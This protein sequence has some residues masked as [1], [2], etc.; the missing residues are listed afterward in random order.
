[1]LGRYAESKREAN[2]TSAVRDFLITCGLVNAAHIGEEES[3]SAEGRER[4]DLIVPHKHVFVEVK[5]RIGT[6]G[7][8]TTPDRSGLDQIDQ[9]VRESGEPSAVGVLTDGK[10]WILRTP[11]DQAG[12]VRGVPY[13]F[14]LNTADQWIGLF[15]WLRDNVFVNPSH[16][17]ATIEN[18]HS[19]FGSGSPVA[20]RHI[21]MLSG[22]YEANRDRPTV[23]V[24]RELWELLL[25]AALGEI[26]GVDLDAL[27]VRH[28][29]LVAVIG[30]ITQA[31]F[32]LDLNERAANDPTDLIVGGKFREKTGLVDVVES[33]FFSWI[34]EVESSAGTL[35]SVAAHVA[36]YTWE[37]NTPATLAPV[38]YET[39]IP[40]SERKH[41]GEYYTPAWL[42][43]AIV[44][45]AVTDPLG[46]TVLD[47]AC[48]SG[49]F[50]VEAIAHAIK[51]A[52]K[53]GMGPT[54]T[55][56]MLQK[57]V[58]GI[59]VHPVAVHLARSAW[60]MAA[61]KPITQGRAADVSVP[62]YLGD[63]LQ[64]LYEKETLLD[65]DE[66]V[67]D[68]TGDPRNR[69]LRFPR[70]LVER[71]E[72]FD[73]V[74]TGTAEAINAGGNPFLVIDDHHL[75]GDQ[76]EVMRSTVA[77]LQQLHDESLNHIWAYYARNLVRPISLSETK[78]DVIVGNPPWVAYR[79]TVS[80]L[81]S[82]LRSLSK[83][84][85]IWV[86][87]KYATHQD[88]AGLFFTRCVDL[89]LSVGGTCSMVM[90]H[91]VLVSGHYK[92]W[93]K[94]EWHD[95][96]P[97]TPLAVDLTWRDAW[98]LE[99]LE[100]NTFFPV[101]ACV[102]HVQRVPAWQPLG[103]SVELWTGTPGKHTKTIVGRIPAS[104][105]ASPY[106]ELA[107]QGATIVPRSLFFVEE[108]PP[109]MTFSAAGTTQVDPR[110]GRQ[111]KA[112][113]K[114]L[115]LVT[116]AGRT[117]EDEH[118]FD[119]LLGETVAPYVTLPPLRAVLPVSAAQQ[120]I[121]T[122]PR[123]DTVDPSS[124]R[125]RFRQ[126]WEE[127]TGLWDQH[128]NRN[129]QLTLLEQLDY[130]KK[131]SAQLEWQHDRMHQ[132]FRVVYTSAGRPT[133]AIIEDPT[134]IIDCKLYWISC[135]TVDEAHYLLGLINSHTLYQQTTRFMPKGQYGPRD[136]HKHLWKLGIPRFD[137]TAPP[138][139]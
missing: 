134:A 79:Q 60:V 19:G 101:P 93:R 118:V 130:M 69:Q 100:P 67:I 127:M 25:G 88:I 71:S 31:A 124:L 44:E 18:L 70:P 17:P 35:R 48:G 39:I 131:L 43:R 110:R 99:Q 133:A 1:M 62:V 102:V 87:G 98:D 85:R 24:K 123:G 7:K 6:G 97:K 72:T 26:R 64:L 46:Q 68:V 65:R 3:P 132:Q 41:L 138:T 49:A 47:P 126:R 74:M 104:Q 32:G 51:A 36:G 8:S 96:S 122:Q 12:Q 57:Q 95:S 37:A 11:T 113:W 56:R 59:D 84:H 77:V 121:V 22:L 107:R 10:H 2:T 61:R 30:M 20:D 105:E 42:A 137:Q 109:D 5:L 111:D 103:N 78:V 16:R 52:N 76:R 50:L 34:V 55:L 38:L 106:A 75:V 117:V 13:R 58:V 73:L 125:P 114:H 89:Y 80:M 86:G 120:R 115:D 27:F 91:S 15:E 21:Q 128:K 54:E 135:E 53:A 14:T 23:R 90:P 9:Y 112:P 83:G 81:R 139:G 45:T 108:V 136:V 66:V 82:K 4:A 116:L 29:Y 33:D 92:K 63:S 28:T 119:V 40:P 129:N 94:G